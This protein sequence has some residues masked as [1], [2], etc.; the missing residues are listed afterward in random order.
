MKRYGIIVCSLILLLSAQ[1]LFWQYA[2]SNKD[3]SVSAR[4]LFL[5]PLG[6]KANS[7]QTIFRNLLAEGISQ[8][9]DRFGTDTE[10]IA[11]ADNDTMADYIQKGIY[12]EVDGIVISGFAEA[13]EGLIQAA[14]R[15][16]SQGIPIVL[17]DHKIEGVEYDCYIGSDNKNAGSAAAQIL[18]EKVSS[19][20]HAVIVVSDSEGENLLER[21][22]SFTNSWEEAHGDSTIEIVKTDGEYPELKEQMLKLLDL[23]EKV[24]AVFCADAVSTGAMKNFLE[25]IEKELSVVGFDIL[26]DIMAA[27]KEGVYA[28]VIGQDTQGM[29]YKAIQY[30]KENPAVQETSGAPELQIPVF[31]VDPGHAADFESIEAEEEQQ[32]WLNG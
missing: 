19:D 27:L 20:A 13:S 5:A 7:N 12:S 24:E 2:S 32:E 1:L 28:A 3:Q 10:L 14:A 31:A 25:S 4:Y 18:T 29:G 22:G 17:L 26:P 30:L 15:A 11:C 9:D 23:D 16:R 6:G 8:G 21:I